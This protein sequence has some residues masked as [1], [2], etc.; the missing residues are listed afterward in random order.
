MYVINV[1]YKVDID[2]IDQHLIAHRDYLDEYYKKGLLL[3]SGPKEPRNGGIIIALMADKNQVEAFIHNDPFYIN[4]VAEYAPIEFC[5]VK[6]H[7]AIK[8]LI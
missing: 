3:C 4:G 7:D 2:I 6:W 8:A 1:N 5:P